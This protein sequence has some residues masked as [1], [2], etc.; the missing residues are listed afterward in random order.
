[1]DAIKTTQKQLRS[2]V[3]NLAVQG[4]CNEQAYGYEEWKKVKEGQDYT[5]VA[6]S[7]GVYGTI[8]QLYYLK[9]DKR[10]AYV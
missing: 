4:L 6:Y 3:H 7:Q 2:L 1:M 9:K 8:A 10:F 5:C